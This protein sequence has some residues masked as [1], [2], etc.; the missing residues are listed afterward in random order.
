MCEFVVGY[1]DHGGGSETEG[2]DGA[3]LVV[4][5]SEEVLKVQKGFV[6]EQLEVAKEGYGWGSWRKLFVIVAVGVG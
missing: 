1:E 3:V 5:L 2:E 6:L 4:E